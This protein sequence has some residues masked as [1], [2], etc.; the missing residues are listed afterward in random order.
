MCGGGAGCYGMQAFQHSQLDSIKPKQLPVS[1]PVPIL[2]CSACPHALARS[3]LVSLSL[4]LLVS[5]TL[6]WYP[7]HLVSLLLSLSLSPSLSTVLSLCSPGHSLS[8]GVSV[9]P[10][11]S[12]SP[13]SPGGSLCL[14]V[15]LSP[16]LSLFLCFFVSPGLSVSLGLCVSPGLSFS[17]GVS[18]S[19][20][21]SLSFGE[22]SV[23]F[24][25]GWG[26]CSCWTLR[27]SGEGIH[28]EA[29]RVPSCYCRVITHEC[30]AVCDVS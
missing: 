2:D 21:A 15:S 18:L 19:S 3:L 10:S 28:S 7:C 5:L 16:C 12:L 22:S 20:C 23:P 26:L 1:L 25:E 13:G 4:S 9:S 6:W 24:E 11:L 27:P 8:P 14:L 17:P 30:L 29:P